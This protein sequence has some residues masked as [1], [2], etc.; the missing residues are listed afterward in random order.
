LDDMTLPPI[1]EEMTEHKLPADG[2][3]LHFWGKF[4]ASEDTDSGDSLRWAELQLYRITDTNPDHDDFCH[5]LEY[6]GLY[7]KQ[8]WLLY[9]VGHSV[10]YHDLDGCAK[11]VK[12]K[13]SDFPGKTEEPLQDLTACSQCRP[14]DWRKNPGEEFRLEVTWYSYTPCPTA[15]KVITSLYR[16]PRCATCRDRPHKDSRCRRCGCEDF[17]AEPRVLSVPGRRLVEKV[18]RVDPEIAQAAAKVKRF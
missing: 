18:S 6:R 2:E 11:G 10:V 16:D 7:G 14:A 5:D 12:I 9:T 4:L 15:G 13:G 8:M 3:I 1:P 17:V